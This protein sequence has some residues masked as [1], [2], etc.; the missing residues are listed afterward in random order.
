MRHLL[1]LLGFSILFAATVLPVRAGDE[2]CQPEPA[3]IWAPAGLKGC[4]LDGPTIGIASTWGGTVA[5]ANWCTHAMRDSRGCGTW[6][7]RS[8]DTGALIRVQP[9][10]YCSC[11]WQ[12][13]RRLIDLTRS[14][15]RAL[16]LDPL[17]GL[18]RVQVVPLTVLP[19]TNTASV[20]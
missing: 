4:T 19:D 11:Y 1:I 15:V 20:R 6:I 9:A 18:F 14:Q 3:S 7:V 2:T 12:T 16:G 10:E 5:A 17:R 13:D 8:I